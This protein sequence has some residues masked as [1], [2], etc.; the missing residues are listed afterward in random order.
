[1]E[2]LFVERVP[3]Y[4]CGMEFDNSMQ[5]ISSMADCDIGRC[6]VPNN[7]LMN[8]NKALNQSQFDIHGIYLG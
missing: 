1:M 6:H 4:V 8:A 2:K 5:I 3:F 7:K